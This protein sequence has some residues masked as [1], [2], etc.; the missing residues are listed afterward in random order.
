MGSQFLQQFMQGWQMGQGRN[1]SMRRD[2]ELAMEQRRQE[3]MMRQ[4][5]QEFEMQKEE[6]AVR[7]KQLAAQEAAHQFEAKRQAAA[8]MSRTQQTL[9][10]ETQ[11]LGGGTTLELGPATQERAPMTAAIPYAPEGTPEV[12]MPFRE[13]IEERATQERQQKLLEAIGF[14][15]AMQK[16]PEELQAEEYAKAKGRRMGDPP[17]PPA[18]QWQEG[19]RDGKPILYNAITG[20][21]KEYPSG[22][23]PKGKAPKPP[24]SV[25]A[26]ALKFWER[27]TNSLKNI[28]RPVS[29]SPNAPTL[30]DHIAK[31]GT[32]A[33]FWMGYAHNSLLTPEQRRY[34]QAARSFTEARLREDSGAAIPPYEYENDLKMYFVQPGD[35]PVTVDQK[36][37]DRLTILNALKNEA[38]PAYDQE[39]GGEQGP[40]G[41]EQ[42]S[43]VDP[44]VEEAL[45]I[46][47]AL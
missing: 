47:G 6:F 19:T 20:E 39:Y 13:D 2:Q 5:A 17:R 7:K 11:D 33:Q 32:G 29:D 27:G 36:R 16:S 45:R 31:S 35:D 26:R 14:K 28:E 42:G 4:R 30:E 1:E 34:I 41:D 38:G 8:M 12:A 21:V 22:V 9:P 15:R 23:Q 3:E 37:R 40:P 25:Q 46:L 10:P 24:T 18:G 43:G 44:A